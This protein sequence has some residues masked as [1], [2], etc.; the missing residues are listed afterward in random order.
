DLG[1]DAITQVAHPP[2]ELLRAHVS[3][4]ASSAAAPGRPPAHRFLRHRGT[5][6]HRLIVVPA[7]AT[8]S[9]ATEVAGI[10][11]TVSRCRA[12]LAAQ[13]VADLPQQLRQID[14]GPVAGI[15]RA[16]LAVG[17]A[18]AVARPVGARG[19]VL[20]LVVVSTARAVIGTR[21]AGGTR[22]AA[23]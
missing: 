11:S 21:R 15:C 8:S 2:P 1:A 5:V 9:T 22:G 14:I 3:D 13:H 7:S 16:L 17:C 4:R 12:E 19:P 18:I 20:G 23:R 6:D 10:E